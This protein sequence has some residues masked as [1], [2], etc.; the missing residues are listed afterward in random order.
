MVP[1]AVGLL[2]GSQRQSWTMRKWQT[3]NLAYGGRWELGHFDD[4]AVLD[5]RCSVVEK[6]AQRERDRW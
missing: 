3:R 6:P 5:W 2:G 4:R 1:R